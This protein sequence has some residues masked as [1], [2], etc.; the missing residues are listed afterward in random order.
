[1]KYI[2]RYTTLALLILLALSIVTALPAH[3]LSKQDIAY[4]IIV[5]EIRTS[6]DVWGTVYFNQTFYV[7]IVLDI[8][9]EIPGTKLDFTMV[10]KDTYYVVTA[11]RVG[12]T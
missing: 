5:K 4:A 12:T 9:S 7:D 1:M 3:T 8:A 11:H 10:Y 2:L 6:R